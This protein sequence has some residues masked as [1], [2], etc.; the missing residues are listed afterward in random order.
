MGRVFESKRVYTYWFRSRKNSPI[1]ASTLPSGFLCAFRI[2]RRPMSMSSRYFDFF[3]RFLLPRYSFFSDS[4]GYTML[5]LIY[6]TTRKV[7]GH[8]KRYFYIFFY[9]QFYLLW[10]RISPTLRSSPRHRALIAP[11]LEQT[12]YF[13]NWSSLLRSEKELK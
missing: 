13:L 8:V 6:W 9:K 3:P 11:D 12:K 2:D 4:I 10:S 5:I 7:K 1:T